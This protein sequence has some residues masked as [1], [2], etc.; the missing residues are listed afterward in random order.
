MRAL[1]HLIMLAWVLILLVTVVVML[2]QGLFYG[3]GVAAIFAAMCFKSGGGR[4]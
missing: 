2:V 1:W 3:A 4:S